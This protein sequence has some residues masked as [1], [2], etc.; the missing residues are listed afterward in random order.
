MNTL[1]KLAL[2][3]LGRL[4]PQP[5]TGDA[6]SVTKLPPASIAGGMPL[7]QALAERQSLREFD[8][9][10]LPAQ[11]LSELLWAAAGVNRPGLGGRTTA[12]AM[13]AQEVDVYAA[14]PTG[15]Y[16]YAAATQTLQLVSA[17]DV[18]RVTGYQD[19]VD[20]A[21]LDLIFVADHTRMKPII[22]P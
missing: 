4:Q 17:T 19:F 20:N 2:G 22:D 3:V 15:L 13:N 11:T 7:M 1:T 5:A 16:R 10:P 9:Q 8:Q 18:R 14:L 6:A 12:S 21:P